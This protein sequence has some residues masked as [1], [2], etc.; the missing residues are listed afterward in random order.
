MSEDPAPYWVSAS[1]PVFDEERRTWRAAAMWKDAATGHELRVEGEAA[2]VSYAEA[3]LAGRALEQDHELFK[4]ALEANPRDME[5]Y[6]RKR[7]PWLYGQS[8]V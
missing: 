1:K 2:Y 3:L 8:S 6:W 5:A 4:R 7:S